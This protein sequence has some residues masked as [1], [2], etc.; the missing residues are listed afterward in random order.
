MSTI[1]KKKFNLWNVMIL[2]LDLIDGRLTPV[3]G[4][5]SVNSSKRNHPFD[6]SRFGCYS[7]NEFCIPNVFKL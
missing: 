1:D 3:G 7:L 6:V 5:Y 2:P 4:P